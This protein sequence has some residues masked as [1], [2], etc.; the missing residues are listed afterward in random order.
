MNTN[1]FRNTEITKIYLFYVDNG[2][3]VKT[4]VTMRFMDQK[5]CYF[6]AA[7]P[8]NFKKPK[9]KIPIDLKV[10]TS[11]GIYQSKVTLIDTTTSINDV[12]FQVSFPKKWDLIQLRSSTRKLAE[13]PFKIKYQD[14][15]T[16][17][18][19]THDIAVGGIS[20]IN[21]IHMSSIYKKIPAVITIEF[22]QN[23]I[24]NFPDRK[25]ETNVMFVRESNYDNFDNKLFSY[26]FSA[27]K[28]EEIDI[29]KM[30]LIKMD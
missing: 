30:F 28:Q 17:E 29:L 6:S 5:D 3:R 26:R 7:L 15:Y 11:D 25:L 8:M 1:I 20:F 19:N 12:L 14:G 9:R 13:L 4:E 16:I 27:L 23:L 2:L 18:G 24:I 10:Y 22:P 21:N